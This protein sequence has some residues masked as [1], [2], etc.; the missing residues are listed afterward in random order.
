MPTQKEVITAV[1]KF[2]A[3]KEGFFVTAVQW[4]RQGKSLPLTWKPDQPITRAQMNN[5]PGNLRSWGTRP[6]V[7]GFAM[8]PTVAAGFI[9]LERQ[10]ERNVFER[11]LTFL[12]FF[13][14][15]RDPHGEVLPGK[16]AGFA[17]AKDKNNPQAYAEFVLAQAKIHWVHTKQP[18]V[19]RGLTINSQMRLL[20]D[21]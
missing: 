18:Q 7:A 1:A 14:G 11:G 5:N 13:A 15:Q 10:V 4:R 6:I 19:L 17:P 21:L 8:F 20:V 12:E 9:A 2:I 3:T 16:Y